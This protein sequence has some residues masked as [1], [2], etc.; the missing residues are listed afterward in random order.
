MRPRLRQTLRSEG[1]S[2]GV[3]GEPS[4]ESLEDMRSR[5]MRFEH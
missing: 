2:S 3:S 5:T 1:T 4:E